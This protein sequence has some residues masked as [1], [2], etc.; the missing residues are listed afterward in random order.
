VS[1]RKRVLVVG[2]GFGGMYAARAL[3]RKVPPGLAEIVLVNPENFMLY[4]PLLA[5]A[6]SG[7]LEPRHVAVPL[8]RVLRRSRLIVGKVT[9]ID[10]DRHTCE[11][12]PPEGET[13]TFAWDYLVL[14]PGSIARLLPI[15][16]LVE[17]ARGF[18]TLPEAIYLR[19]HVL[20]QL[21]LADAT[22][23]AGERQ[24][25]CTFVVVGA[26]YAGTELVG[27]LQSLTTRAL[28]AYPGLRPRDIHWILVDAAPQIMPELGKDLGRV[29]LRILRQR[30]IEVRLE[31]QVKEVGPDWVRLSDGDD[32]STR[33]FVWTAG[34]APS[35]LVARTGLP[36]DEKRRVLVDE[37]L[38]VH[39]REDVFALGDSALVPDKA[40]PSGYAPPTAQHALREAKACA[41]NLAATLGEGHARPFR[42]RGLGLLVNLGEYQ[43]VARV[44][45]ISL[46]GFPGWFVTRT[47]H[48]AAMPT[49]GRR[50]RVMLDWTIALAFP[51]D[52]A[53]LS[54]LGRDD[55]RA[56][57]P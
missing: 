27:E 36:T 22:D 18:K 3:E 53:E 26:G 42:F 28:R 23:D 55:D 34:V 56:I 37:Y 35:P 12:E 41:D 57:T 9:G 8:R 44:L 20:Q 21:E 1:G 43:G 6:A 25:R 40:E 51:R 47:Y 48:L 33:T 17:H 7:T 49:W 15:P 5:E 50:L 38:R 45:S 16:G 54:S 11:V 30:G 24:A 4:T 31:T 2:G 13:R 19:N 39:G 46:R 14:A 32:I 52:I 10:V 29:A